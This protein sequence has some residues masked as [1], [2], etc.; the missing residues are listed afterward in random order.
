MRK[1]YPQTK[2]FGTLALIIGRA[3]SSLLGKNLIPIMGSASV[4]W[5]A[6]AAKGCEAIDEFYASSDSPEVLTECAS[7]D[8]TKIQ[9]P[10]ELATSTA[11][12]CDVV[13][14]ALDHIAETSGRRFEILVLLHANAPTVQTS[15]I[16]VALNILAVDSSATAAVPAF[17]EQDRHPYRAKKW[18]ADGTLESFFPGVDVSSNRQELPKAM[19]L[20]HSFWAVRLQD[21]LTP[22]DG[23]APWNCLG[24]KV[25]GFEVDNR[26]DI[27]TLDDVRN[28]EA[29]LQQHD[30]QRP[31]NG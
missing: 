26:S 2:P 7:F 4:S 3:G 11:K 24:G 31:R 23:E 19:F 28:A 6:S 20:A 5:V 12:G 1:L 25:I 18:N 27:H 21:G 29:W 14:H 8:F 16:E 13:T 17:I 30:V 10:L 22:T 15:E 9:R